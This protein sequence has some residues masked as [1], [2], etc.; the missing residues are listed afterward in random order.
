VYKDN[1]E[2]FLANA[3]VKIFFNLEDHFSREYVSKLIG[4]TEIIRLA[5][6]ASATA[7]KNES[8]AHGASKSISNSEAVSNSRSRSE[9]H[10]TNYSSGHSESEGTSV[11]ASDGYA[12]SLGETHTPGLFGSGLFS[13]MISGSNSQTFSNS[14]SSSTSQGSTRSSSLGRSEGWGTA[15]TE[16]ENSSRGE[17]SGE[18][19]T[20]TKGTSSSSTAGVS[21]TIQRRPLIYPDEI[22]QF[23]ATISDK[24]FM[25]YP[26]VALVL[27]AGERPIYLRRSYYYDDGYFIGLF[28]KHPDHEMP[29]TVLG[30]IQHRT[31]TNEWVFSA[32]H[33]SRI[34]LSEGTS[35]RKGQAIGALYEW[36]RGRPQE[37]QEVAAIRSPWEGRLL[38]AF[39]LRADW[40]IMHYAGDNFLTDLL[41]NPYGDADKYFQDCADKKRAYLKS[42][43][44]ANE[45]REAAEA[46]ARKW[47]EQQ[48]RIEQIIKEMNLV[49]QARSIPAKPT[50]PLPRTKRHWLLR[51]WDRVRGR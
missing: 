20:S 9:S 40:A 45:R 35:V 1:W 8:V 32:E 5:K 46:R 7:G 42:I 26:G 31:F 21:E 4:D 34:T 39:D 28:S 23:F 15:L 24:R 33:E 3:G 44:D 41:G 11:S 49:G 48:A 17:T 25:D 38:R 29:Q 22:G 50:N 36:S 30:Q 12:W 19:V 51:I 16:S 10:G 13:R 2:T 27:I 6:S 43:D 18:S 37:A 14:R 47:A